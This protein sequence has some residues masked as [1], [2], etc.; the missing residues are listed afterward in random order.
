MGR[1][2]RTGQAEIFRTNIQRL[3][4][5]ARVT[6]SDVAATGIPYKTIKRWESRGM[7]TPRG[8]ESRR[9]V[10]RLLAY[11][12]DSL[13]GRVILR[14]IDDL[15]DE[16]LDVITPGLEP[17]DERN[18]EYDRLLAGSP[19]HPSAD[20]L[21]PAT[22]ALALF[23]RLRE[24]DWRTVTEE[25]AE[26]VKGILNTIRYRIEE[27]ERLADASQTWQKWKEY[28]QSAPVSFRCF[29]C[30]V[31]GILSDDPDSKS[32]EIAWC[33]SCR[34]FVCSNCSPAGESSCRSCRQVE[35]RNPNESDA[36]KVHE[37]EQVLSKEELTTLSDWINRSGRKSPKTRGRVGGKGRR[38]K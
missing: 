12:Q 32:I 15:W 30:G 16:A 31:S 14:T 17:S 24:H 26:I 13:G 9:N 27:L 7:T 38:V 20:V 28:S 23:D 34:A 10:E 5:A 33:E 29:S 25:E 22:A 18:V 2:Q 6:A 4:R 11:F 1:P 8:E 19:L 37:I 21:L 3:M 35:S 36:L